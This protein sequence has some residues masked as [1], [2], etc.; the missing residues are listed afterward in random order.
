MTFSTVELLPS[1]C[2]YV[3]CINP[4]PPH[5]HPFSLFLQE[6]LLLLHVPQKKMSSHN[7]EAMLLRIKTLSGRR[8]FHAV[9][10]IWLI[11][12]LPLIN[13]LNAE[14]IKG[15]TSVQTKFL[16]LFCFG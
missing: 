13:V 4:P 11:Y 16:D 1:N 6:R 2:T 5:H 10:V 9:E 15:K 12:L 3:V 8:F 7:I 14:F